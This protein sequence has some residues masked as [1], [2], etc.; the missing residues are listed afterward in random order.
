MFCSNRG[1]MPRQ[2]EEEMSQLPLRERLRRDTTPADPVCTKLFQSLQLA[3]WAK[4][5]SPDQAEACAY[6]AQC[7]EF[8]IQWLG[9][10]ERPENLPSLDL[11]GERKERGRAAPKSR[12]GQPK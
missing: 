10:L 12:A 9:R 3:A 8:L 6:E 4:A 2:E 1:T 7:F 11:L 5:N